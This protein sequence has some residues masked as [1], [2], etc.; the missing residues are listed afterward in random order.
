[1]KHL[2][3]SLFRTQLKKRRVYV[4]KYYSAPEDLFEDNEKLIKWANEAIESAYNA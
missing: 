2:K 1:M 3:W 4:K